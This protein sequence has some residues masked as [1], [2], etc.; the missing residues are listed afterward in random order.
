MPT[1]TFTECEVISPAGTPYVF[2]VTVT[3]DT[4]SG[5]IV[6]TDFS[7]VMDIE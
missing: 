3:Y 6:S 1:E 5:D 2:A 4:D 7:P